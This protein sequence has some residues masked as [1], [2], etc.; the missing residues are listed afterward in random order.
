MIKELWKLIQVFFIYRG[1]GILLHMEFREKSENLV[2]SGNSFALSQK[3]SV[4]IL[5]SQK[6][7]IY[8]QKLTILR[9]FCWLLV[10]VL[11]L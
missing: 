10:R 9:F 11:K 5:V 8:W 3:N 7:F 6:S 4:K 1:V 2:F